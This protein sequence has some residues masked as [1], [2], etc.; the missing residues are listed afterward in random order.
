MKFGPSNRTYKPCS[1]T[2]SQKYV[3]DGTGRDQYVVYNFFYLAL[4]MEDS[5]M[6]K[7]SATYYWGSLEILWGMEA[8]KKTKEDRA[9][10]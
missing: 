5:T 6:K 3:S 9:G 7:I 4:I 8:G 2:R 1:Y 10:E